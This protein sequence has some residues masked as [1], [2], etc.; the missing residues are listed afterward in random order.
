MSV[1]RWSDGKQDDDTNFQEE[2]EEKKKEAEGRVLL[3]CIVDSSHPAHVCTGGSCGQQNQ[4]ENDLGDTV[5]A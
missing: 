3:E 1:T 5:F 4:S 2:R